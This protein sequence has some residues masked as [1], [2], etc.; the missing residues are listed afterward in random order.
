M[1]NKDLDLLKKQMHEEGLSALFIAPSEEMTFLFGQSPSLCERFQGMFITKGGELLYIC[2]LLYRDEVTLMFGSFAKIYSWFDGDGF[3][4]LTGQI[5]KEY[6]LT[7]KKIGVNSAARASNILQI[8][9]ET[10]SQF[11]SAVRILEELRILKSEE[12]LENLQSSAKITDDAYLELVKLIKPGLSER[13]IM[14]MLSKIYQ[15]KGI[16]RC[17]GIIASGSNSAYPHYSND[18]RIIKDKDIIIFD[19][20][21]IYKNMCSDMTRTL[22]VGGITEKEKQ[23]YNIVLEA[24]TAAEDLVAE[25]AYIPDIDRAAREII[26]MAGYGDYFPT[27][28]GHGIGYSIHEAPDIKKNNPRHLQKGMAFSIEPG[29]YLP[30]EFGIRIEDIVAVTAGGRQILNRVPKTINVINE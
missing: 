18:Q 2:N 13:E 6:K 14:Q 20:G 26:E 7:G 15:D 21:C 25:G 22:F 4:T 28:L 27:R 12:E 11:V 8:A 23:I 10:G 3:T 9:Q 30:G 24:I 5:L 19:I 29:I 17:Y 1:Q 16:E